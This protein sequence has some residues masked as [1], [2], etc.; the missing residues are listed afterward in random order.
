MKK[1]TKCEKFLPKDNFGVRSGRDGARQ[2]ICRVCE[3]EYGKKYAKDNRK[4]ITEN[5]REYQ[6]EY[7]EK[8]KVRY[9]E[10]T[11]LR[12]HKTKDEK[13]RYHSVYRNSERSRNAYLEKR[14]GITLD[15]FRNIVKDQGGGCAICGSVSGKANKSH[16]RLTVDHDHM[17]GQI[18]GILCHKCNFGLGHFDDDIESL[19]K[20][21]SYLKLYKQYLPDIMEGTTN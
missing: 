15:D 18:R 10:L 3:C 2:S 8:Y 13:K 20:A 4:K 7:R 11:K 16:D 19:N 17:T 6:K 9:N 5:R 12:Y 21:I 14:Y 1:C